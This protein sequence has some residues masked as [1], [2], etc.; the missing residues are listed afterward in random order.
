MA[1]PPASPPSSDIGG[2]DRDAH[3]HR[4]RG[5]PAE[6]GQQQALAAAGEETVARPDYEPDITAKG[7]AQ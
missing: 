7:N 3:K 6:R 5:K 2:V 1:E 4:A